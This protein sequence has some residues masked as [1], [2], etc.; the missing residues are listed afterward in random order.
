MAPSVR[1]VPERGQAP[2]APDRMSLVDDWR[3]GAAMIE[4]YAD[5]K[6]GDGY[7]ILF[8]RYAPEQAATITA[9]GSCLPCLAWTGGFADRDE[10][11]RAELESEIISRLAAWRP[12]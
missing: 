7:V 8:E 4:L 11:W 3:H 6:V 2:I 1:G 5:A 12:A 9:A 10:D